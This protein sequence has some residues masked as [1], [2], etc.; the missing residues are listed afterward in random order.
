ML[1]LGN[2]PLGACEYGIEQDKMSYKI[3]TLTKSVPSSGAGV[4]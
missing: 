1:E 2:Y 3:S 4:V